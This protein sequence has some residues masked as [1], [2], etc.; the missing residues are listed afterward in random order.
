MEPKESGEMN[1]R[2]KL[3]GKV[4]VVAGATRGAGRG[5][6]RMLGEAG[7]TVYCTGRSAR[8]KL[9]RKDRPETIDETAQLVTQAGGM[10]L[11]VPVDHTDE[12]QVRALFE[13]VAKEQAG[14]LD[15]LVNDMTGDSYME[16]KPLL[17]HSVAKG[18]KMVENG[19]FSHIITSRYAIPLMIKNRR[20]LI[21]EM[22]DGVTDEIREFNFYYDLEKATNIR[23]A[24]ALALYLRPHKIAAVALTPG[25]LRSE[26]MLDHFGVTEPTWREG[27]KKDRWFAYSETP[28][29]VGK[30]VVALARDRK[31]MTK[32]G[33]ALSSGKLA[34]EYGFTDEDG[35]QPLWCY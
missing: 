33:Q 10:G 30:A 23:L 29:Y 21:V 31:I 34:R 12:E 6:A 26:E 9:Q 14:R 8:G 5:I 15:L 32:S 24:R 18:L 25:F 4:A 3:K 13:R 27:I 20:G 16:S 17:D 19:S 28:T 7:A 2:G 35:S 1:F 11:A 22:T